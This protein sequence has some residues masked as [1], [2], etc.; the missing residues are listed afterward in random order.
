MRTTVKSGLAKTAVV[1]L[2][3]AAVSLGA[4][5]AMANETKTHGARWCE[6]NVA[7]YMRVNAVSWVDIDQVGG[8]RASQDYYI[9]DNIWR[10]YTFY[11]DVK[12]SSD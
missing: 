2:V 3:V 6:G 7:S 11:S 4:S 9:L 10:N 1:G 12:N 5:P 8:G